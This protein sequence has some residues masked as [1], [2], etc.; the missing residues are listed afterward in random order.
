[1]PFYPKPRP[2]TPFERSDLGHIDPNEFATRHSVSIEVAEQLVA[3]LMRDEIW[4]NSRYQV[5]I[6][7]SPP[8]PEGWPRLI[9]VSIKRRD[10]R[11]V[12]DWRDLQRIKN[13]LIGPEHEALELYP[14]ESRLVD[15][16]NQYHLWVFADAEVRAPFG[17]TE[18]AVSDADDAKKHGG[19]QRAFDEEL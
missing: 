1:M 5:N 3:E 8:Q 17:W 11:E 10:K 16:A 2:W 9:H 14:A 19:R 6:D 4:V 13:E 18:R 7:R 15:T 12:H